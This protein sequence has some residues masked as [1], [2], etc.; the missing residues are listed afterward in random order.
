[1]YSQFNWLFD[2]STVYLSGGAAVCRI[3]EVSEPEVR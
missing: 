3:P 1:M 2:F